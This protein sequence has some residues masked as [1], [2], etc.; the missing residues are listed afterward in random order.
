M[1]CLQS[2]FDDLVIDLK[3]LLLTYDTPGQ[4]L[5]N[6]GQLNQGQLNKSQLNQGQLK[7]SVLRASSATTGVPCPAMT[8]LSQKME[9]L[10]SSVMEWQKNGEVCLFLIIILGIVIAIADTSCR[11]TNS[12]ATVLNISEI[13]MHTFC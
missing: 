6:Q 7:Q 4:G 8:S 11:D 5:P 12:F 9:N 3:E 10:T 1:L 13:L 2:R